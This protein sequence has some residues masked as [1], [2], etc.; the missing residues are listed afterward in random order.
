VAVVLELTR[1][2][3]KTLLEEV[4]GENGLSLRRKSMKIDFT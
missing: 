4:G 1:R 3:R 2:Q